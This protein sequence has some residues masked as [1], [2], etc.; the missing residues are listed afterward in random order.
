MEKKPFMYNKHI[1]VPKHVKL[2]DSE[3][4]KLLR[5]Y[6]V[7]LQQ[8]PKIRSKDPA[9]SGMGLKSGDVIKITRK[10]ATIRESIFYRVV[11]DG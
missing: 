4:D 5:E 6:N 10:S 8:L 9:L 2:S 1:L 11:I 7:A 3:K